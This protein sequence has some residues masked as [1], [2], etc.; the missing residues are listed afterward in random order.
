MPT[1]PQRDRID[2]LLADKEKIKAAV[3]TAVRE[4]VL[5]HKLAGNPICGMKDGQLVWIKPE[6]IEI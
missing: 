1:R 3:E 6:E 5:K 4:A 2:E